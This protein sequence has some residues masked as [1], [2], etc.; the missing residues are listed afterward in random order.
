MKIFNWVHR[1][2]HSKD[3]ERKSTEALGT[4]GQEME[5]QAL[6][7]H[8][9][10][11]FDNMLDSLGDGILSIGTLGFDPLPNSFP[12]NITTNAIHEAPPHHGDP[13]NNNYEEANKY[14]NPKECDDQE[15]DQEITP[16]VFPAYGCDHLSKNNNI[17]SQSHN[18]EMVEMLNLE[19]LTKDHVLK[20]DDNLLLK[21][22]KK[23]RI[24]LA[25]L[26]LADPCDDDVKTDDKQEYCD[27]LKKKGTHEEIKDGHYVD[28]KKKFRKSFSKKLNL[29]SGSD[30]IKKVRG[31]MRKMIKKKIHPSIEEKI[32]K[33]TDESASLLLREVATA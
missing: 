28:G 23:E 14:S 13:Q 18:Y 8:D 2:F 26:F 3:H 7:K 16:L 11:A 6:L 27:N 30:P 29:G 33:I 25:D 1:K 10:V 20:V 12:N 22:I 32:P 31:L 24:T 4:N 17:G 5:K 15:L 19:S 21:E 9:D